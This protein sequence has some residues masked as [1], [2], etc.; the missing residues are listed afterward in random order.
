MCRGIRITDQPNFGFQAVFSDS[1]SVSV[2]KYNNQSSCVCF[3]IK[4]NIVVF[5]A[6]KGGS[7]ASALLSLGYSLSPFQLP[8]FFSQTPNMT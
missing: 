4:E 2:L 1:S 3:I 5:F 6:L 8:H 7:A